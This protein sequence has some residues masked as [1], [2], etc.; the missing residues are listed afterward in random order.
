MKNNFRVVIIFLV[1]LFLEI[2]N[3]IMNY[4]YLLL[5]NKIVN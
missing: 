3:Y 4:F 5:L 2:L 1:I